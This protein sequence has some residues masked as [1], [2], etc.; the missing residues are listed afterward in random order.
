[1][2]ARGWV[3]V[4]VVV[5]AA[6]IGGYV[7]RG[8]VGAPAGTGGSAA[9]GGAAAGAARGGAGG[10]ARG[11]A[12]APARGG[13]PGGGGTGATIEVR[14]VVVK[15]A[16]LVADRTATAAVTA[17]T[18]S[19]VAAQTGGTV[20]ALLVAAGADVQA[21]QPIV[22][23]ATDTL[24]LSLANAKTALSAA[25]INLS[26]QQTNT[27]QAVAQLNHQLEAAQSALSAAE[28]GYASAQ[29]VYALGGTSKASVDSAKSQLD[30]AR[31]NVTSAQNN[32]SQNQR[33]QTGSLQ[34][35][36]LAVSQAQ[37]G[38][39]QAEMNL[40]DA[41]IRAPFAGQVAAFNVAPGE[42]V[43]PSTAVATVVSV[44]RQVQ[45]SVPPSDATAFPTGTRLSFDTGVT[46]YPITVIQRPGIPVNQGVTVTA[47]FDGAG[48]GAA[49]GTAAGA[50][51]GA[52]A[53][54]SSGAAKNAAADPPAVGVVGTVPYRVTLATAT[55]VPI[56]AVQN[57]GTHTFV[58]LIQGGKAV[59]TNLTILA[60]AGNQAAVSGVPSGA[61]VI[62]QPPPG[63]LD[64]SSVSTAGAGAPG[65]SV[66]G[67]SVPARSG[68]ASGPRAASGSSPRAG[69]ASGA[70]RPGPSAAGTSPTGTS[71]TGT[72]PTGTAPN[73]AG[74]SRAGA[75]GN[76][77][78]GA[79]PSGTPSSRRSVPAGGSTPSGGRGQ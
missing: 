37:N 42:Y 27:E 77:A 18:Q 15:S 51:T 67:S 65:G 30:Q 1:V 23:L 35:L 60:Q 34:Q 43:G 48:P 36:R 41:T 69:G 49:A 9:G 47:R 31:A 38:V 12:G 40:A 29:K 3:L 6:G 57:D 26:T 45:M 64:G 14:S 10:F 63:L 58:F 78:N 46:Q 19:N 62:D 44:D 66:P 59:Q 72:S 7:L 68:T 8:R 53:G 54:S 61:T 16:P 50:G 74:A 56:S 73:A 55:I 22:Q 79:E 24:Q 11:G 75:N 39:K 52:A 70:S 25:E 71:P 17:V 28:S 2:K 5:V 4:I 20:K 33:A 32:L 21:E 76:S 13:F